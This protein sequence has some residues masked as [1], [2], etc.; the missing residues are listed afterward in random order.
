MEIKKFKKMK[1]LTKKKNSRNHM[2]MQILVAF[3]RKNL[4]VNMLKI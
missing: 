3:A 4:N 2:K 1:L